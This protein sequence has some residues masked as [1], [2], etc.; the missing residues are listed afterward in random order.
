M[1]LHRQDYITKYRGGHKTYSYRTYKGE[2]T[3]KMRVFT[4]KYTN[5][6]LINLQ[7]IKNNTT[8]SETET[9]TVVNFRKTCRDKWK[10]KVYNR[11]EENT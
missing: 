9:L 7:A 10:R 2:E 8:S 5:S 4:L 3:C 1:V 6:K 11:K